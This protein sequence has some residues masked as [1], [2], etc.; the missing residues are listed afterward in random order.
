MTYD[1]YPGGQS[2]GYPPNSGGQPGGYQPY[3]GGGPGGYQPYA[4]GG[5]MPPQQRPPAPP[6]VLNAVRLMYAGAAFSAIAA[7]LGLTQIG[8]VRNT[9]KNQASPVLTTS[10]VNAAVDFFIGGVIVVGLIGIALWL[11]M[12]FMCKGGKN[13]ARITG[14]VFFAIDTILVLFSLARAGAAGTLIVNIL[15]WLIGLGAVI[16][17]W[18]KE[19]S[20]FFKEQQYPGNW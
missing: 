15:A 8:S 1:P 9:L 2:G 18:R 16:L 11:W 7:I 20:A 12:A 6:S 5:S 13:W 17:L 10:Q 4:G 3:P 19:S 14:T